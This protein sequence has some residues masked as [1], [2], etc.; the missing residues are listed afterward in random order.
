MGNFYCTIGGEWIK[1][2]KKTSKNGDFSLDFYSTIFNA[3]AAVCKTS[4]DPKQRI[5]ITLFN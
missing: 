5:S 4:F 2:R 3:A 1:I